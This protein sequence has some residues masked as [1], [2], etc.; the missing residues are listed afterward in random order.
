MPRLSPHM[1]RKMLFERD[2]ACCAY[3][4]VPLS[5]KTATIDHVIPV[6]KGGSRWSLANMVLACHACNN[7]KGDRDLM[8]YLASRHAFYP[9]LHITERGCYRYERP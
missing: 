8:E 2:G 4:K 5:L 6:S 7:E 3:C 1:M 9:Q